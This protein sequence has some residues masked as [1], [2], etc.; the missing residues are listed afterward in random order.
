LEV[1]GPCCS[2]MLCRFILRGVAKAIGNIS[3]VSG[4]D[5]A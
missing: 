5:R 1:K 3:Y 4:E 2:A